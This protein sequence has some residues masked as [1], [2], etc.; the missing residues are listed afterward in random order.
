MI[1]YGD[2][3]RLHRRIPPSTKSMNAPRN[4][5]YEFGVPIPGEILPREQWVQTAIKKLPDVPPL[6]P[7]DIFGRQAPLVIDLGCGNGRF[8]VSSAVRRPEFD[9][10]GIDILPVVIRYATR[11]GNQ[12]GLSNLR[13][14]VCGGFEFLERWLA[15]KSVREIHIYHPQPYRDGTRQERRL[16]T[17]SFLA[18]VH[19]VLEPE[20]TMFLQTDHRAYW[21]Y[22]QQV[23]PAFFDWQLQQQSWPEDRRG[24]TR[25]EI[26]ARSKGLQIYRGFG[27]PR[28]GLDDQQLQTRCESLPLP[29]WE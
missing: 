2:G 14:A 3:A 28:L 25:R 16:I 17:P 10:L 9:H 24:R 11:R 1:H 7:A 6:V 22:F 13:F 26:I 19:R 23:L 15:P 27:S 21:K 20:G 18:L 8:A 5:E 29:Q 4:I 12:R